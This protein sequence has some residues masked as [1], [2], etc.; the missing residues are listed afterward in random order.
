MATICSTENRLRFIRHN[1]PSSDFAEDSLSK[2][3]NF[4]EAAHLL[5]QLPV[6]GRAIVSRLFV[7]AEYSDTLASAGSNAQNGLLTRS[8]VANCKSRAQLTTMKGNRERPVLNSSG[9]PL[10]LSKFASGLFYTSY[11]SDSLY[12]YAAFATGFFCI[13][14]RHSAQRRFV[15]WEILLRPAAL[16]S[17][18]GFDSRANFALPF[19]F[20]FPCAHRR[21]SKRD[22]FLRV[23]ELI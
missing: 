12:G 9:H 21:F 16:M 7:G 3:I 19:G 15:A 5:A 2:W 11:K 1:P 18:F 6:D 8:S 17:R 14:R 4:W 10:I 22:S 20:I 23:A 13:R